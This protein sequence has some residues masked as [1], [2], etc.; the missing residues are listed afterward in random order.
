MRVYGVLAAGVMLG[1]CASSSMTI[2]S[3]YLVDGEVGSWQDYAWVGAR[4]TVA[5]ANVAQAN[6]LITREVDQRLGALGYAKVSSDN[7]DFLVH[8]E[9]SATLGAV[10]QGSRQERAR[11]EYGVIDYR[12]PEQGEGVLVLLFSRPDGKTVW[13]GRVQTPIDYTGQGGRKI[14]IAIR[15]L[16]KDFPKR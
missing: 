11:R 10:K 1:A 4:N 8:H 14:P 5:N 15:E 12:L 16:L 2:D 7:A 3:R 13:E 6:N 9:I